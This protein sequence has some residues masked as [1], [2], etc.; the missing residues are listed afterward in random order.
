MSLSLLKEFRNPGCEYRGMPFWSWNGNLQPDELRRQVRLMH[1]GGLG[2]FFMH[3]R[4]GLQ[5]PYLSKEW[6]RCVD[7]CIDE[8]AKLGMQAWLYD[9]DRWPSGAAGGM[10]T[11]NP[12]YR[13]RGLAVEQL[14]GGRRI[15]WD[16]NVVA[17]FA[18]EVDG[19]AARNVR[20]IHKGSRP[21][22]AKHETL[23]VFRLKLVDCIDWY[24]GFTYLDTLSHEAVG[25]FIRIT[26]EAYRK[27]CGRHFGRTV[28][29]IFTDEPGFYPEP[30]W[31]SWTDSLPKT[32]RG[33]YGYDILNHLPELVFDVD[34]EPITPARHDYNDCIT[35]LFADA[36]ARQIG[37]WC[38]RNK[39]MHTGHVSCE[40]P[41]SR[42]MWFAGSAMRFS[43]HMQAPGIDILTQYLREYDSA[44]QV[45]S[46]GRQFG[47]KWRLSETYGCSGWDFPFAGHKAVSDWQL[48]LGINLRCQHL[49]FYTME[50]EAKRDYPASIFYQSPWWDAY[51]AVEDYYARVHSVMTRGSEVRDLLVIHPIESFWVLVNRGQPI[52]DGDSE[53]ERRLV[54]LRDSLLGENIDFDYGDE[55]I[56]AR[57]ARVTGRGDKAKFVV[58][59][60][61][62]KAVLVPPLA[63]MRKSTLALLKKFRAAGG[64]V[65]FEGKP[66]RYVDAVKSNAA[67]EFAAGCDAKN[68]IEKKCRRVSITDAAGR[69]IVPALH[70][71]RE[72]KDAFY[73]FVCNT[74]HD[75]RG[76]K[77][78]PNVADR[79]A[80][81]ENVQVSGFADCSGRPVELDPQSGKHFLADAARRGGRWCIHT[82]LPALGS[83]LFVIP[84]KSSGPLKNAPK[85]PKLKPESSQSLRQTKWDISLSEPNVLPLD[86]PECRIGRGKWRK[87]DEILQV[88]RDVR[89]KLGL[90]PRGGS[91]VQPWARKKRANPPAVA[92][93]LRYRFNVERVPSGELFLAIERP[94]LYKASL[95]G[96]AIDTGADC[97]WWTDKSLRKL[98]VS[99]SLLRKGGNEIVL[100]CRYNEN[101]PGLEIVYLLGEFGCRFAGT[102]TTLTARPESLKTGDWTRQG[103]A[104]YSGSVTY[105][106]TISPK[107]RKGRRLFVAVPKYEGAAVRVLVNG[108]AVGVIAWE[109]NEID[110]TDYLG[111]DAA[112]LGIEV[113]G[114]R[115]NSHG[116]LHCKDPRPQWTGPGIFL[117]N[118]N[119]VWDDGYHV[120]PMGLLAQPRLVVKRQG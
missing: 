38:S 50:G 92:I 62:Y 10:V 51:P 17:A 76:K 107:L 94:K 16:K 118:N 37:Q 48:A 8:A 35:F 74:G 34:G 55:D 45:G 90:R 29:G 42:Q 57:C 64:S 65:V 21:N 81:F 71:L 39:M 97:G 75:F 108:R 22:P 105:T 26:H 18:A 73:L 96:K 103:L 24:N 79:T 63:T 49:S 27:H 86:M 53:Y 114:S 115:R 9:E 87:C 91:M 20:R 109:P 36:F 46:V 25:E 58:G 40:S 99:P 70:M 98:R 111:G 61:E 112:T 33:R 47:R 4:I 89:A 104:F 102:K 95:N 14:K 12:K 54:S 5:T 72:D 84:K 28:P 101:H 77:E 78:D 6:F 120:V 11:K 7:A 110:I 85:R 106:C 119:P 1:D 69:Q 60:A 15:A 30:M 56:L 2:G 117:K 23:I 82:S 43:E 113:L 83:R 41:M 19:A 88:D 3:S 68:A 100:S 93:D 66:P 80:A 59:K 32:F 116:P 44:K 67:V 13:Q 52:P 31:I